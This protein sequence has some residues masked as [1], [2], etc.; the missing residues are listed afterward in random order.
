MESARQALKVAQA[1]LQEE[2]K[3]NGEL[4]SVVTDLQ[5][6]HEGQEH[7]VRDSADELANIK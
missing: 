5:V 1:Q 4:K 6:R 3:R 7:V 2:W